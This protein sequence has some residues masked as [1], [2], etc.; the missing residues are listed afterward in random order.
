MSSRARLSGL[1][2]D[3]RQGEVLAIG[4]SIRIHVLSKSGRVTRLRITAP[5]DVKVK[6]E[7][8]VEAFAHGA[9]REPAEPVASMV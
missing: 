3:V 9:L 2:M 6:K 1:V 7:G 4:G 8:D 5:V